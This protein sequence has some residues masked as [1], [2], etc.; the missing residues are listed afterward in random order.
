MTIKKII[1][2]G[3]TTGLFFGVALVVFTGILIFTYSQSID[4]VEELLYDQIEGVARDAVK[5]IS[6]NY[7]TIDRETKLLSRNRAL[8]E[9]YQQGESGPSD[10][11]QTAEFVDWF[12]QNAAMEYLAIGYLSASGN[13]LFDSDQG[14]AGSGSALPS[15]SNSASEYLEMARTFATS[16]KDLGLHID[17]TAA[18]ELVVLLSRAINMRRLKGSV[19][20]VVPVKELLQINLNE[21]M[22]LAIFDRSTE[23]FIYQSDSSLP[24][25]GQLENPTAVGTDDLVDQ[26]VLPAVHAL[27]DPPW[28][29]AVYMSAAPYLEKP[30]RAGRLTLLVSLCFVLLCGMIIRS[31]LKRVERRSTDLAR[32][33]EEIEERNRRLEVAQ[34]IVRAH[35]E[36]LEAEL[37]AASSMQMKLMPHENPSLSGFSISGRCRPATHVGGDFFQYYPRPDGRLSV[38]M[39]D[40]TGHGMEAAIPTVLF[41]G[42]LDNQMENAFPPEELFGRLN[43][44]LVR[45]LERRTFV[46]FSVGELDP[47]TRRMRFVNGGCPYPYHYKAATG[48]TDELMLDALPLGLRAESEYGVLE[49]ELE[50]GDRVVF[51]SDGIIE[52]QD[53]DEQIFGFE[54]TLDAVNRFASMGLAAPQIIDELLQEVD[55]FRGSADQHDD[56]TILVIEVT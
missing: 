10:Q 51:C 53:E 39:A 13:L 6:T 34:E 55:A 15:T 23:R 30:Q 21:H 26:Q 38:A 47:V 54:R 43:R 41:S 37:A 25:L 52:A 14:T 3:G 11:A 56:Q 28:S 49:C 22:T 1:S 17:S 19:V 48:N 33:N 31:L 36:K 4:S 35:N 50:V 2:S 24:W 42:M 29:V 7:P 5:G 20:A 16:G 46:C 32:A 27:E 44:S 45:N 40:V 12:R 8:K 9:L 18:G